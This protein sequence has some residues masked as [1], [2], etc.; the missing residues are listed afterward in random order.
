MAKKRSAT[1]RDT[2][3][4]RAGTFYAKRTTSG[5]F[6]EMDEVGRS[7]AADRRTRAKRTVASGHGDQ[8]DRRTKRAKG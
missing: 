5:R 3:K 8:G 1:A 6:K 7:L 4:S 2:V